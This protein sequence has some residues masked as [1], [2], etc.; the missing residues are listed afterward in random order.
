MIDAQQSARSI[1]WMGLIVAV[2]VLGACNRTPE[3]PPATLPPQVEMQVVEPTATASPD[4]TPTEIP[5]TPTPPLPL[6]E[7]NAQNLI[8]AFIEA[9]YR[10]VTVAK[11][12]LAPYSLIVVTERSMAECGSPEEPQRC[13]NDETCGSLYTS[14]TCYFFVE[15]AFHVEADPTTRYVAR[16]PD[17]PT[18]SGLVLNSFRFV[19]PRTVEFQAA[20]GD[21]AYSVQ[22]VWWLDLVTG[23]F[24]LQSR[25]E[26][27]GGD[28]P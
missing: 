1:C 21:G 10:V 3:P 5:N 13:T 7:S 23:A 17:E 14:P 9:P 24:A 12:P 25:V 15:P 4:P 26:Q 2:L 19:D 8:Q 20:G 16:W 11:S 6:A 22:E 28:A 27:Q 18:E